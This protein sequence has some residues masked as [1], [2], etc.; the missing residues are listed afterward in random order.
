MRPRVRQAIASGGARVARLDGNPAAH[1]VLVESIRRG[2][3]RR[4]DA[5]AARD[6]E[7]TFELRIRHP[8]G[9]EPE[10]FVLT[11]ANGS[12]TIAPGAAPGAGAVVAFGADDAVALVSGA[13]AWPQLM[14]SGRLE[15]SGD[16]FLGLRF[17]TLFRL[18]ARAV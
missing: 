16:P 3:P 12:C 7:A 6:L 15:L 2:L 1:R 10:R 8:R 14:S 11:V 18:P 13:A 17:P 9:R 5:E 4:L